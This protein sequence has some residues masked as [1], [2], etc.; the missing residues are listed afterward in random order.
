MSYV[1]RVLRTD[2][3]YERFDDLT[4]YTN[5][6]DV[7]LEKAAEIFPQH[8]QQLEGMLREAQ[9]AKGVARH[10]IETEL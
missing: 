5:M 4:D 2:R 10:E 3:Q 6:V 8:A 7:L 9:A 1:D